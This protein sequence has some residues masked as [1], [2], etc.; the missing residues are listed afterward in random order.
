MYFI[1]QDTPRKK[2]RS[3]CLKKKCFER[4]KDNNGKINLNGV[5]SDIK[6]GYDLQNETKD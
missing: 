5:W 6:R 3:V 4:T 2:V 1:E